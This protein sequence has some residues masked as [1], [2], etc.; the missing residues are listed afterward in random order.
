MGILIRPDGFIK[1]VLPANGKTFE[2]KELNA[3]VEGYIE[4]VYLPQGDVMV[5]N[6][7]GIREKKKLNRIATMINV[8]NDY[9]TAPEGVV[10]TVLLTDLTELDEPEAAYSLGGGSGIYR[11]LGPKE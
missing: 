2:L 11:G 1:R 3:I 8:A 10:G 4:F 9:I 5:V 6:E 7:D